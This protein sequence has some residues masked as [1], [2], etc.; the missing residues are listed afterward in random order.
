MTAYLGALGAFMASVTWAYASTHYAEVARVQGAV[1]VGL[2]RSLAAT[3]LWFGALTI[4]DGVGALARIDLTHGL[5]LAASIVC[6]YALGDRIF[7]ASAARIGVSSALSIATIYPLWSALYG[8]FA[9][10][11]SLGLT[12]G[13]GILFCLG[14]VSAVLQL[15]RDPSREHAAARAAFVGTGLALLTSLFWAGNTVF[16]K[17]GAEGVSLYAANTVRFGTGVVLLLVQLVGERV[18]AQ[19]ERVGYPSLVRRLWLPLLADTG[20]GSICFIYGIANTDLALGATL[21]SLSP[22]VALPIAV[23]LGTERVSLAKV[24]AVCLTLLGVVLLVT[25]AS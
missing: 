6:S 25:S 10:G 14:G 20:L 13:L 3:L 5:C 18:P 16:L 12:R 2:L 24:G 7:F 17:L 15:S 4:T 8:T 19:V 9:R 1:R 23:M 11:E 21:S 22:L